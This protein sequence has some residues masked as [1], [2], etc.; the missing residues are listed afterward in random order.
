LQ[1]A[2]QNRFFSLQVTGETQQ[3]INNRTELI[4]FSFKNR[5]RLTGHRL[6]NSKVVIQVIG[7]RLP[8]RTSS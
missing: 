7:Y 4:G 5:R 3:V 1:V 2:E 8:K 6:Q